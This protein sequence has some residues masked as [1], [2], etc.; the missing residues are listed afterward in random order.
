MNESNLKLAQQDIDD[1]LQ[2][3]ADMEK[4]IDANEVS[5][6]ILKEKFIS[7]TDKVQELEDILKTEGIL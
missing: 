4:I 1:A 6:E 2:T 7:L 3:V 5:K